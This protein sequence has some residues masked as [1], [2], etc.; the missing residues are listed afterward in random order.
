MEKVIDMRKKYN[1]THRLGQV[2]PHPH[3]DLELACPKNTHLHNQH[4]V[5]DPPIIETQIKIRE[6]AMPA[7][8]LKQINVFP[9]K[10]IGGLSLSS[11]WVEK[12]GLMFDRRFMVASLN[13]DMVTARQ[14]PKMVTV[15]SCLTPDGIILSSNNHKDRLRLR[16]SAFKMKATPAQVFKDKFYAYTT[17]DEADDWFS[18]VLGNKVQVLFSGEQSTRM[19]NKMDHNVSF[20]DGYPMLVI[21]EAS[22]E[23]L[24]RRSPET[25]IMD[26]FRPNLV[27]QGTDSFEEDS[28]KRIRIADVEFESVKPCGRCIVTTIDVD[29]GEFRASKEPLNTLSQ[30]RANERGGVF[31]GQYLVANNEGM[32]HQGDKVEVLAYKDKEVYTDNSSFRYTLNCIRREEIARDFVTFWF[33]MPEGSN[34]SYLPGQHLPISLKIDGKTIQRRYTLSS[35]PSRPESIA[36]SVK[37]IKDGYVSNWLHNHFDVGDTL[38]AEKPKGNFFYGKEQVNQ[39]LLLLS[40]GSGVTP[41]LS[42]LRYLSDND[43]VKDVVF[44]HQCKSEQDKPS[45]AEIEALAEK[46][47]G[48]KVYCALSRPDANWTGLKGRLSTSHINL[49]TDPEKRQTFVCGPDSFMQEAKRLLQAKGLPEQFYHQEEFSVREH[50]QQP[51][52]EV[53]LTV[54]GTV[55]QG[56]NQQ[57]ILEQAEHVG[58]SIANSCRAG[59]CGICRMHLKSGDVYQPDVPALKLTNNDPKVVLTCCSVPQSDVEIDEIDW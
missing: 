44:Y 48:L 49:I 14:Y 3:N 8:T 27:V 33:N 31:F 39:P 59:V 13:G 22:L 19:L 26:Q 43:L 1:G 12:Q 45:W 37:R 23:E 25:H 58:I 47:Q 38:L 7:P 17:T 34:I 10:S 11:L 36:I 28:W 21:S 32:I 56:N 50:P 6:P 51:F 29:K 46:H 35:S 53:M 30:F 9:V 5:V 16:Y 2:H 15:R 24:N 52:K 54:N 4:L 55:F 20:A 42:I 40:A 18:D 41:M 57:P